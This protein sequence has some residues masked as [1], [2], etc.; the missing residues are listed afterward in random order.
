M[1][2]VTI[3]PLRQRRDDILPMA[4]HLLRFFARQNGK[5]VTGFSAAAREA[6][7]RY[8]W[9]GNIREL[10]NA[11][12]RGVILSSAAPI[13]LSHL[14]SHVGAAEGAAAG[15]IESMT[16]DQVEAEHIRRVLASAATIEDAAATLGI[17]P[18]TCTANGRN[19]GSD[20][21]FSP[22]HPR[23]LASAVRPWRPSA[24][25]RGRC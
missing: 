18:S 10:R 7:L 1:I 13:E 6:L 25:R 3:P 8:P 16:L 24:E 15:A 4:E 23:C 17:D 14:P 5:A 9:P 11:V 20:D 2:E 21:D 22:T 19:T 12:E